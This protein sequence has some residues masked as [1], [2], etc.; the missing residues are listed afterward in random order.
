MIIITPN[1]SNVY[2]KNF[3]FIFTFFSLF[4]LT[5]AGCG[6]DNNK[7]PSAENTP[8]YKNGGEALSVKTDDNGV[9]T[10]TTELLLANYSL[11]VTDQNGAPISGLS[12]D[13]NEEGNL[14]I[15]HIHDDNNEYMEG[16]IIGN[17]T[18]MK[19]EKESLLGN[20][21]N[22]VQITDTQ[23]VSKDGIN[24]QTIELSVKII[25]KTYGESNALSAYEAS[26]FYLTSPFVD[27]ENLEDRL[28][29]SLE[30]LKKID[31]TQTLSIS[32]DIEC[33]P[34]GT[35]V[36]KVIWIVC[37]YVDSLGNR[38]CCILA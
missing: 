35:T 19:S 1:K 17:P 20:Y 9:A 13:Y 3:C 8:T 34:A 36:T 15:I 11:Q 30:E 5:L 33:P 16:L 26:A 23:A 22:N 37:F 32:R 2:L 31:C 24:Y 14:S 25:S 38:G 27:N 29:S 10:I 6:E 18:D 7:N 28:L 4:S 12:V 21:S